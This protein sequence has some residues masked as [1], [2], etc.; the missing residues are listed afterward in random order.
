MFW[1]FVAV[2][3]FSLVAVSGG[4]SLVVVSWLLIVAA[5]LVEHRVYSSRALAVV[6]HGLVAL[7]HV[8]C[9]LTRA[10]THVLCIG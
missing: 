4:Y 5:S 1:V 10:Q 7:R 9:P 8:E 3:G 2:H 6:V